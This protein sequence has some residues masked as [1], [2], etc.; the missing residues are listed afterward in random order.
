MG[1]LT[2][3]TGI[4]LASC[5]HCFLQDHGLW[6][7][8]VAPAVMLTE[9]MDVLWFTLAAAMYVVCQA[10]SEG[11]FS[12]TLASVSFVL[13]GRPWGTAEKDMWKRQEHDSC[14]FSCADEESSAGRWKR[15]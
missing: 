1:A 11:K 12:S 2:G 10:S 6:T 4:Q 9:Q 7:V 8:C 5:S 15:T 13:P 14:S 3:A